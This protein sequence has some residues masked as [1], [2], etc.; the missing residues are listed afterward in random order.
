M[1]LTEIPSRRSASART[2]PDGPAPAYKDI[3]KLDDE[4]ESELAMRIFGFESVGVL[5]LIVRELRL[6]E[7][8]FTFY[9]QNLKVMVCVQKA[10]VI[11]RLIRLY[12]IIS[13]KMTETTSRPEGRHGTRVKDGSRQIEVD[14]W[15]HSMS[16]QY[17]FCMPLIISFSVKKFEAL[18]VGVG[19]CT[20]VPQS[21]LPTFYFVIRVGTSSSSMTFRELSDNG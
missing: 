1:I 17:I 12:D 3:S 2:R 4:L 16:T 19:R 15:R 6:T 18:D 10:N 5:A 13:D 14:S 11:R 21:S 20:T 8:R 9:M 7:P